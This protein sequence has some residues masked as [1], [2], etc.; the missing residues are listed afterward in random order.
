MSQHHQWG[1]S[2]TWLLAALCI[3]GSACSRDKAQLQPELEAAR[4]AITAGNRA[5][6]QQ[7]LEQAAEQYPANLTALVNLSILQEQTGDLPAALN[8]LDQAMH[9]HPSHPLVQERY[10]H[11]LLSTGNPQG[12]LEFLKQTD[13]T[14]AT[15]TLVALAEM[16]LERPESARHHLERA[17]S[18][19][20][21][22]APALY[23]LAVLYRDHFQNRIEAQAAYRAFRQTHPLHPL[24]QRSDDAFLSPLPAP[25]ATTPDTPTLPSSSQQQN[26]QEEEEDADEEGLA[27]TDEP[28]LPPPPPQPPTITPDTPPPSTA[29]AEPTADTLLEQAEAHIASGDIDAALL[30]L[31]DAVQSFPNDPDAVWRLAVFYDKTIQAHSRAAGLY[32]TFRSLFPEDPRVEQ[33][34]RTVQSTA[35]PI[36]PPPDD[37]ASSMRRAMYFSQA[38]DHYSNREW[39]KAIAAYR[40]VLSIRPSDTSA[41]FNLGLSY[42]A[43]GDLDGAAQAFRMALEQ[44]PDMIKGLYMLGLTERDRGQ[45]AEALMLLNRLIR[46]QPDYA[47]AHNLLGM[48]YLQEKRPDMTTIHFQRLVQLDPD[49]KAGRNAKRWLNAHQP[50][51]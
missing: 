46:L 20:A 48:I 9:Q 3:L 5:E 8:T 32:R 17:L 28:T 29:P 25:K 43:A 34:P 4:T 37:R 7:L 12:V 38:Q 21:N 16:Q 42:K 2:H 23:N 41:A 30:T 47:K 33:I 13:P 11:L 24:A 18:L 10:A 31:K 45:T 6:A 35:P 39:D 40:R 51:N 1:R 26:E 22:Y 15:R 19:D 49:S 14:P 27:T 44:E 50:E 36:A